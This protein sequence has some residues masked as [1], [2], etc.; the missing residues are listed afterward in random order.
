MGRE[1]FMKGS[2]HI[3][4]GTFIINNTFNI[5]KGVIDVKALKKRL[6]AGD[7]NFP[8]GHF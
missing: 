1:D 6:Q 7:K 8:Q 2:H 4:K 5:G 3:F